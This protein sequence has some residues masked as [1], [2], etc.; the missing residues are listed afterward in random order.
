MGLHRL[1]TVLN[2]LVISSQSFELVDLSTRHSFDCDFD[3]SACGWKANEP[4][5]LTEVLLLPCP[6]HAL[7]RR[8]P[9]N[10]AFMGAQGRFGSE[11]EGDLVSPPFPALHRGGLLTFK[12]SK[13]TSVTKL[14]V[15]HRVGDSITLLD[16]ISDLSLLP[17][18]ERQV[19]VPETEEESE[20][21][22]RVSSVLSSFDVVGVDEV[23]LRELSDGELNQRSPLLSPFRRSSVRRAPIKSPDSS[24]P[25]VKC[26]FSVDFCSWMPSG[27]FK[28]TERKVVTEGRGEGELRSEP[29]TLPPNAHINFELFTSDTSIVSFIAR[30]Q[31]GEENIIWTN[32]GLILSGWNKI[33]MPIRYSPSPTTIILKTTVPSAGFVALKFFDLT[34]EQGKGIYCG[35]SISVIRPNR[36]PDRSMTRLTAIQS[37]DPIDSAQSIP[38]LL[39][40][41][42]SIN[43]PSPSFL[44]SSPLRPSFIS[45][46][47]VSSLPISPS[48]VRSP[49][50][51]DPL[52]FLTPLTPRD[53]FPIHSFT[54]EPRVRI[55]DRPS[56]RLMPSSTA[57]P[58]SS[59]PSASQAFSNI[60]SGIGGQPILEAQLK[61]IAK[62][63]GFD[64]IHGERAQAALT[65]AK[66]LFGEAGVNNF[67]M[68]SA[69]AS[70]SSPTIQI[71]SDVRPILPVNAPSDGGDTHHNEEVALFKN[72]PSLH[73][74]FA[75]KIQSLVGLPEH[76]D[77]RENP[78]AKNSVDFIVQNAARGIKEDV[79]WANR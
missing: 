46:P 34:D 43:P 32:G 12:Y 70:M 67:L 64:N 11:K 14:E 44:S 36:S 24:C 45:S 29:I 48:I 79:F 39:P 21:V 18:I 7:P 68:Q 6:V 22:F 3:S 17:W 15:L 61:T 59:T 5:V 65:A 20:I 56:P 13:Q 55:D 25:A 47:S 78:L 58:P 30:S 66:R 74:Q 4:W 52:S 40:S 16:S 53:N 75:Q 76:I 8:L 50:I 9:S 62:K 49:S 72:V 77:S 42:P 28:I 10:G 33:R 73:S 41:P 2:L 63:F 26:D 37:I 23:R 1:L 27:T 60:I 31:S 19:L 71:P 51:F 57:L 35:Q 69:K 54:G 38:S